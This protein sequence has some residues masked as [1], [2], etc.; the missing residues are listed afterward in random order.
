LSESKNNA[1][2]NFLKKSRRNLFIFK[3]L[4][5]LRKCGKVFPAKNFSFSAAIFRYPQRN[6]AAHDEIS[7][8]IAK[9]TGT[10]MPE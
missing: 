8:S 9:H 4:L 7:L 10:N 1:E 3:E 5:H 2:K 6:F